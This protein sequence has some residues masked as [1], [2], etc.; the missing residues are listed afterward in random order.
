VEI[1]DDDGDGGEFDEEADVIFGGDW[2]GSRARCGGV[3][4]RCG[5]EIRLEG[6]ENAERRR[7]VFGTMIRRAEVWL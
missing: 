6:G 3:V 4:D 7:C 5:D 1:G 2:E